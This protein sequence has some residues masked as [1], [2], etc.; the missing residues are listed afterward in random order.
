MELDKINLFNKFKFI[1]LIFW[2]V[3]FFLWNSNYNFIFPFNNEKKYEFEEKSNSFLINGIALVGGSNVRA[4]LSSSIISNG[5]FDS[6]NFGI[7]SEGGNFFNYVNFLEN[8]LMTPRIIVYSP[9]LIWS[10]KIEN[11]RKFNFNLPVPLIFQFSNYFSVNSLNLNQFDCFGDQNNYFCK[12]VFESYT[13]DYIDFESNNQLIAEELIF[14][15]NYLSSKFKGSKIF[16][17]IPPVYVDSNDQEPICQFMNERINILKSSGVF[18]IGDFFVVSSSSFFCD[19][20]HPNVEG[21]HLFSQ[22]LLQD[23]DS[24]YCF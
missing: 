23:I 8:R 11:F 4:G 16:I 3:Y 9:M 19:N 17:R 6:Y 12:E 10:S 20:V 14:R 24:V 5:L 22:I 1:I 2:L 13:V 7:S 18:I 15:I 21:R